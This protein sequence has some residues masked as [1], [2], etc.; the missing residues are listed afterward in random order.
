M[1]GDVIHSLNRT[2]ITCVDILREASNKLPPVEPA[3]MQ[4]ER[5]GKL[6][7]LTFETQ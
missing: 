4:V 7:Y 6:T 1:E 3:A 5:N 2:P